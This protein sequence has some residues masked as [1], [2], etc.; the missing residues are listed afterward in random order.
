MY[1][2]LVGRV[3]CLSE[4][5]ASQR[6]YVVVYG[7]ICPGYV[8]ALLASVASGNVY[9]PLDIALPVARRRL[10]VDLLSKGI[11][12][13]NGGSLVTT[14][15]VVLA[16]IWSD[17]EERTWIQG[18]AQSV[19]VIDQEGSLVMT[20][21]SRS[22]TNLPQDPMPFAYVMF[23]SGT[24][25]STPSP[26]FVP[27]TAVVSNVVCLSAVLRY[28]SS[29]DADTRCVSLLCSPTMF[30][31]SIID[32]Y[33][34]FMNG[35]TLVIL[36]PHVRR[37][38][39]LVLSCAVQSGVTNVQATPSFLRWLG[40]TRVRDLCNL[41]TLHTLAIG[42]EALPGTEELRAWGRKDLRMV[43]L[44][45]VTEVS[46]WATYNII[47]YALLHEGK[48]ED[49]LQLGP[50]L[51]DTHIHVVDEDGNEVHD[52]IGELYIAGPRVCTLPL[53]HPAPSRGPVGAWPTRDV[54]RRRGTIITYLGRADN[55][56]KVAGKRFNLEEVAEMVR[57]ARGVVSAAAFM[58][59]RA[60]STGNTLICAFVNRNGHEKENTEENIRLTVRSRL[61][62]YMCPDTLL[63][64]DDM[65]LTSNGKVD[66]AR[67][68]ELH[69]N[70]EGSTA[71]PFDENTLD[72]STILSL[73][74]AKW[75]DVMHSHSN[76]NM[77]PVSEQ[78]FF[79]RLG[80]TSIDAVRVVDYIR[81]LPLPHTL[82]DQ[83]IMDAL[84][85]RPL[86]ELVD[87]LLGTGQTKDAGHRMETQKERIEAFT[88]S[89]ATFLE[90]PFPDVGTPTSV[91]TKGMSMSM[92][93][94][95][96]DSSSG[97]LAR[98]RDTHPPRV[99]WKT[100]LG[101]CVDAT[102]LVVH[103]SS[104]FISVFVG[105]HNG[106]LYSLC[107]SSGR[108]QWWC[109]L[110]GRIEASCSISPG[111]VYLVVG[112]YDGQ[113]YVV[114][115]R[116]GAIVAS[117]PCGDMIKGAAYVSRAPE[118][119]PSPGTIWVGTHDGRVHVLQVFEY[120]NG[121]ERVRVG[122]PI[123]IWSFKTEGGVYASPVGVFSGSTE[124]VYVAS[125]DG[126][127][128]C[129]HA[130]PAVGRLPARVAW[131]VPLGAPLFSTPCLIQDTAVCVGCCDGH[132]C[133]LSRRGEWMWRVATGGPV[134][135]SPVFIQDGLYGEARPA[136][137]CG[138]HDGCVY[139]IDS[140]NGTLLWRHQGSQDDRRDL[141]IFASPLVVGSEVWVCFT[142]GTIECISNSPR[143]SD[144]GGPPLTKRSK[145]GVASWRCASR[146]QVDG[147]VFSSP[148]CHPAGT[149]MY[150]GCRDDHVYAVDLSP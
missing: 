53:H 48:A 140:T 123:E 70:T 102:P 45:G 23:T 99:A 20:S 30:D 121:E 66:I 2:A 38:P 1:P 81:T 21:L 141:K 80:G 146:G 72:R 34:T 82:T 5:L 47:E 128:Y 96:S 67:L 111:G 25:S 144:D 114:D 42:G 122:G 117:H 36:H 9:I 95:I 46:V 104:S 75:R 84:L 148:V 133:A 127:V 137:V 130:K 7:D 68:R 58:T 17:V 149:R 44:Y 79:V 97:P 63:C 26:V 27:H 35:G 86:G 31:P 112:A 37:V 8:A 92:P 106:R 113:L 40:D 129:V 87:R 51:P 109:Q 136:V 116:R 101:M 11:L 94:C 74:A 6:G 29:K 91:M 118:G 100:N 83:M 19:L 57:G 69:T 88:P 62:D 33:C 147:E 77:G 120:H 18:V 93:G 65:P 54:V 76:D 4:A 43:N 12:A 145:D 132:I 134:Y 90:A 150:L 139:A 64:I 143:R 3:R 59:P 24:S 56:V 135:C 110:G 55:T 73:V 14:T 32:I 138:S 41:S 60:H 85:H 119:V 98:E 125:Q 28:A 52:G 142:D 105:A 49:I 61:P 107:G 15:F 13:L 50:P 131:R 78:E 108:V 124:I 126:S 16:D 115:P 10:L 89:D 103:Y 71:P 22:T 39:S